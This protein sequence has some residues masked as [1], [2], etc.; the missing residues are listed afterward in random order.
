MCANDMP[1]K[2]LSEQPDT[3]AVKAT[4]V[5]SQRKISSPAASSFPLEQTPFQKGN[6]VQESKQ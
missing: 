2:I 6:V 1:T 4:R 3:L 5:Y